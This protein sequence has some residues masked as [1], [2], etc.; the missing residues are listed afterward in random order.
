LLLLD[1]RV[2]GSTDGIGAAHRLRAAGYK[3]MVAFTS[4]FQPP[5]PSIIRELDCIWLPKPVDLSQM[6]HTL[7][8]ARRALVPAL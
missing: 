7:K 3:G 4:A 5:H 1:V 2:L 6:Q 8:S